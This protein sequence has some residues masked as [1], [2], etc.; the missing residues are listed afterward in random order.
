MTA[1]KRTHSGLPSDHCFVGE[2]PSENPPSFAQMREL[3]GVATELFAMQPWQMLNDRAL[4]MVQAGSGGELC[5]CC[6]M[7]ALGEVFAMHAYIGA[8]SYRLFCDIQANRISEPGEYFAR[9]RS[10]YVDYVSRKELERQD[11]ELL[12][13]LDHPQGKGVR[14]PI[15]RASRPGFYPWFVNA[16]EAR[17]LVECIRATIAVSRAVAGGKGKKFWSRN[18]VFPLVQKETGD[19]LEY[20]I[21]IVE[22]AQPE[23]APLALAQAD[24]EKLAKL[25]GRDYPVRG[26]MELDY[27][28]SGAPIGKKNERKACSAIALAV[29]GKTGIVYPPGLTSSHIPPGDS[30]ANVFVDAVQASRAFP[31]EVRVR[32]QRL[33]DCLAPFMDSFGVTVG[34]SRKLPAADEARAHLLSFLGGGR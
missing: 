15:F 29:D 17:A 23:E 19:A 4:T 5:Y 10:V 11:R 21:D 13:W 25:R 7:G 22:A 24:P 2:L 12:A 32:T 8:E 14:S 33:S 9:Q 34:V 27:I 3:Y 20:R 6:V 1:R 30:L 28:L 26:V 31:K 18:G 16:E